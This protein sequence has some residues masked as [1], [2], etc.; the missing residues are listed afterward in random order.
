MKPK[1]MQDLMAKGKKKA[2]KPKSKK[3]VMKK[4]RAC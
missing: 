2:P 4:G 3:K 1:L